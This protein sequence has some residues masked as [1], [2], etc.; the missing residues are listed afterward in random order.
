MPPATSP[1]SMRCGSCDRDS[2]PIVAAYDRQPSLSACKQCACR[3]LIMGWHPKTFTGE[4]IQSQIST[5][6]LLLTLLFFH[7]AL[8]T[9]T[10]TLSL[11]YALP[12]H[13]GWCRTAAT[14]AS[15]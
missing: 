3:A 13:C 5:G 12:A 14:P 9:E 4:D 7:V 15:D 10:Y 2:A 1:S 8:R 11:H 6:Y